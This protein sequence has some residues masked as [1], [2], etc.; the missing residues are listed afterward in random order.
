M[1]FQCTKKCSFVTRSQDLIEYHIENCDA[2]LKDASVHEKLDADICP[3]CQ[4]VFYTPTEL[5]KHFFDEHYCL[6]CLKNCRCGVSTNNLP[7]SQ[8][9]QGDVLTKTQTNVTPVVTKVTPTLTKV[10]LE[11]TNVTQKM[12]QVTPELT[13]TTLE[14]IN[15]TPE[16]VTPL[17]PMTPVTPTIK[18]AAL[19]PSSVI[20]DLRNVPLVVTDTNEKS[21][22][23]T[24]KIEENLNMTVESNE[25]GEVLDS[26]AKDS[27]SGSSTN[28]NIKGD[29]RELL[30]IRRKIEAVDML[31]SIE[32]CEQIESD[33]EFDDT[34][35]ENEDDDISLSSVED[36]QNSNIA[37]CE[38][39]QSDEDEP[40]TEMNNGKNA[41]IKD[42][43]N[44]VIEL[45]AI[46]DSGI[47]PT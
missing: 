45:V 18:N 20:P 35:L 47:I 22:M 17:T 33:E 14:S 6:T 13:V 40:N 39:I 31:Q 15:V 44:V 26:S 36:H 19:E 38:E 9:L 12:K 32:D 34:K 27:S 24:V 25:S 29:L 37:N 10:T 7:L 21:E 43:K 4:D 3:V 1:E 5:L 23:K 2:D 46:T 28:E 41:D 30:T 11:S 8:F 16:L 42:E